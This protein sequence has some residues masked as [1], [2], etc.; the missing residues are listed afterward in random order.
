VLPENFEKLKVGGQPEIKKED[1]YYH[2]WQMPDKEMGYI[3]KP[4]SRV[5]IKSWSYGI[6][7]PKAFYT[8]DS[9]GRRETGNEYKSS[10]KN[11]A[12]FFGCSVSFGVLVDD[13]Q[14]LPSILERLDTN[15]RSYNYGVSGYGTHHLYALL[16]NRNLKNE[17]TETDGAAFYIYFYGHVNRAMGDMDSYINWNGNSPYYYLDD[18]K[19]VRNG[20][21]KDGRK[22]VS[23]FYTFFSRTYVCKYFDIHLPGKL[24][25]RHYRFAAKL[26]EE[27]YKEY[28][29]Q[30]GNDKFYVLFLPGWGNELKPFLDELKIK[31]L[32][33]NILL[34]YWQDK[35]HFTGDG[36]PRPL[37][38]KILAEQIEKDVL[39][40]SR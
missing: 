8:C 2:D 39:S 31:Y 16:H 6:Q 23:K 38:Y 14:T 22:L 19:I 29:R 17:I 15:Y 18:N 11:Y 32:D 26:I 4:N 36:H 28:Q 5:E 13:K 21:F 10:R 33:Y 3:N 34:L 30:F 7:N 25:E 37:F 27:S 24:R 40:K 1:P 20:N 9:L 35:Y 12:L